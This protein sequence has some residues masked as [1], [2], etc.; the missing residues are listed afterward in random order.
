MSQNLN[1]A[2]I[3]GTIQNV[4]S[5]Y[6]E[7]L[8]EDGETGQQILFGTFAAFKEL[9]E[10]WHKDAIIDETSFLPDTASAEERKQFME[11]NCSNSFDKLM[12]LAAMLVDDNKPESAIYDI[13]TEDYDGENNPYD[14]SWFEGEIKCADKTILD[15]VVEWYSAYDQ[16]KKHFRRYYDLAKALGLTPGM[17]WDFIQLYY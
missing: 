17:V 15:Y 2:V 6:N 13:G 16:N 7:H 5:A 4:I 9:L 14:Y 3:A 1:N 11:E 10:L 12:M 8:A